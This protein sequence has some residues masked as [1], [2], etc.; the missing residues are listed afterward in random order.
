MCNNNSINVT[1]ITGVIGEDVHIVGIRVLE[2]ALRKEGVNVISLG[3]QVP[4]EEFVKAAVMH[5]ADAIFVSSFSGH[6]E[7]LVKNMR[8]MCNNAGLSNV[9]LYIGGYLVVADRPWE[10]VCEKF[11]DLGFDRVYPPRT[12]PSQ[13]IKDFKEDLRRRKCKN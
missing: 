7:E 10:E 13:V 6:A 2:A 8:E 12:A 1:V 9:L 3:A 11:K 5:K 4:P